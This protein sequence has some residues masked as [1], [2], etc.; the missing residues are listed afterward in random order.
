MEQ[1]RYVRTV[2]VSLEEL[3][4]YPGN[5]KR[6]DVPTILDSFRR[7]GQYRSIIARQTDDAPLTV[8]AGNHAMAALALHGS[9]PCGTPVK[10]RRG[11]RPC[12]VCGGEP[13][14]PGARVEIV[15]CDDDTARRINLV[16][17]KS[18]ENGTYDRDALAELLSYVDEDYGGTGYTEADVEL[19]LAP[20]PTLVELADTYGDPEAGDFWPVLRFKVSPETRDAFYGLTINCPNPNDDGERLAYLVERARGT[21]E[22]AR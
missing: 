15:T 2:E 18:A 6:G 22:P 20:P 5:A 13:W 10:T 1:A 19:L 16:D 21:E 9:G 4:P 17:N 8:L 7:N 3:R 12:A 14:E 11:E